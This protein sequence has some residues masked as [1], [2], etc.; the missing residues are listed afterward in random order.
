MRGLVLDSCIWI[1]YFNGIASA[2]KYVDKYRS[3][4]LLSPISRAEALVHYT[5]THALTDIK[6]FLDFF[7]LLAL[8]TA[9]VDL[10]AVIR[11]QSRIKLTDALQAATAVVFDAALVTRDVKD[12]NPQQFPF[13]EVP[14]TV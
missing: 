11:H 2:I 7:P 3:A 6:S 14:Y 1:D 5:N 13:V 9:V 10:A 4:I 12:F 8:N